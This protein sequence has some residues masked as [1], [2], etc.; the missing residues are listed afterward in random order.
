MEKLLS[1]VTPVY[2]EE[3][4]IGLFFDKIIPVMEK[5]GMPFEVIAVNDGSAD[6]T[7]SIIKSYCEKDKRIKGVTFSRNFGQM[8][9]IFCGLEKSRGDAVI[10]LD[11]DL[12]DS[13]ETIV[14]MVEK[15]QEG[16]HVVN[17]CRTERKG[18]SFFKKFTAKAFIG[19]TN[20]LSG[21]KMPLDSGEFKLYDRKIVNAI[22]SLP[23]RARYLRAQTAWLG[24]KQANVYFERERRVAGK[25]KYSLKK[26]LRLAENAIVPNSPKLLGITK[27]IALSVG[28]CSFAAFV[29]FM[30]LAAIGKGLPLSA[31]LFPSIGAATSMIMLS[32]ALTDKYLAYMYE[33]IKK[34][35]I[36][37]EQDSYNF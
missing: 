4:C 6:A 11:S 9:A 23:E 3:D 19:I 26:M 35:P 32:N 18:E 1:V 27:I 30:V 22:I 31:W 12:Q 2:N 5:I 37:V 24:F 16:Y 17:A 8:Q 13:P 15:W 14:A 28:F 33:D 20:R 7:E 21:L 29:A 10:V 34:R 36:Y 25:T